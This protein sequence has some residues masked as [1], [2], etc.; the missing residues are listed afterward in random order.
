MKVHTKETLLGLMLDAATNKSVTEQ[1]VSCPDTSSSAALQRV[2]V[3]VSERE[4]EEERL[5]M[6]NSF[7]PEL[8]KCHLNNH[9]ANMTGFCPCS[10]LS[11]YLAPSH[12]QWGHTAL[13]AYIWLHYKAEKSEVVASKWRGWYCMQDQ[14]R[15]KL[16]APPFLSH[17]SS[18][19]TALCAHTHPLSLSRAVTST[20]CLL[21]A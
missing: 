14:T 12:R 3:R 15:I 7:M 1:V 11:L 8:V 19:S 5:S 4:R 21:F 10:A 13:S 18:L 6:C 9:H 2:R 16:V 17:S 20:V